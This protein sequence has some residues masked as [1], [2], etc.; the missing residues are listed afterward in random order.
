MTGEQRRCQKGFHDTDL[1]SDFMK[2]ACSIVC[3]CG[4]SFRLLEPL[5]F[6]EP[7]LAFLDVPTSTTLYSYLTIY[8][9][10]VNHPS[11]ADPLVIQ[12]LLRKGFHRVPLKVRFRPRDRFEIP[13]CL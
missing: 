3:L 6:F 2:R 12:N 11:N 7:A 5:A 10:L 8:P 1:P 4:S 9:G 13:V